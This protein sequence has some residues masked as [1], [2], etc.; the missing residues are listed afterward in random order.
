MQVTENQQTEIE[1]QNMSVIIAAY[2]NGED[3]KTHM[4]L[5]KIQ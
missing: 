3:S 4:Y 2:R 5:Q 1:W